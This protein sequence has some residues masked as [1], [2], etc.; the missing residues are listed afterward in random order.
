MGKQPG[1]RRQGGG[2]ASLGMKVD[3]YLS[4]CCILSYMLWQGATELHRRTFTSGEAIEIGLSWRDLYRLRDTGQILELSR[5]VWRSVD[6]APTANEDLLAVA[7]RAPRSMFCLDTALVW[8]DLT[9][10]IP[11]EVHIA[12]REGTTRPRIAY[13]R[14]KV[15]VYRADTF[16]LG[17]TTVDAAPGEPITI[18]NAERTTVDTFRNQRSVGTATANEALRRYLRRPR[19]QPGELIRYARVLNIERPVARALEILT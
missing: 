5:G 19:A 13:P 2:G 11:R 18:T 16:E 12:V 8:W 10:H 3:I 7:C 9:D 15:H 6:A 4:V 1:E 17:Q 14:T